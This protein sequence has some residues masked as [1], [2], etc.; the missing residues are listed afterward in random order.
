MSRFELVILGILS[1][2][3][4]AL[5]LAMLLRQGFAVRLPGCGAGSGCD[6]LSATRWAR[7]GPLPVVLPGGIIY[8]GLLT[9]CAWGLLATSA[10]PALGLSA[11]RVL[12]GIAAGSAIWLLALQALVIRRFCIYCVA[13]HAAGLLVGTAVCTRIIA[14]PSPGLVAELMVAALA[15][16]S[17]ISVQLLGRPRQYRVMEVSPTTPPGEPQAP[18][19][20]PS[21]EPLPAHQGAIEPVL[22][23][24]VS[25][26]AM[27]FLDGAISVPVGDWPTLGQSLGD[28]QALFFFDYTCPTC[29]SLHRL[30][31]DAIIL[32]QGRMTVVLV[33]VPMHPA[34]NPTVRQPRY[35]ATDACGYARLA[36]TLWRLHPEKFEAFDR[37]IAASPALP[38][39]EAAVAA[40]DAIAGHPR[41]AD[42][43]TDNRIHSAIRLF[44]ATHSDQVPVLVTATQIIAGTVKSAQELVWLIRSTSVRT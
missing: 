43:S 1:A 7:W 44:S 32:S 37:W 38:P 6:E 24:E 23:P 29:H 3:A 10:L 8:G 34:C 25:G 42:S 36:L 41:P 19:P 20:A 9:L 31:R 18:N 2:L 4:A 22:T 26:R 39:L 13:V 15:L 14:T 30:L 21:P 16:A 35:N 12:G 33:P 27:T 28:Q 5:S 40:A 17:L 11:I